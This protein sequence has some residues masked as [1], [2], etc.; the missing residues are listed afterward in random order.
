MRQK[1]HLSPNLT[2]TDEELRF[3]PILVVSLIVYED[4]RESIFKTSN[5]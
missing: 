4:Y 5:K 3:N 1:G 2:V